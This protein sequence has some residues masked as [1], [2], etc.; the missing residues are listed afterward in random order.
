MRLIFRGEALHTR[1]HITAAAAAILLSMLTV[2]QAAAQSD[3][4][5]IELGVHFT[6]LRLSEF[7]TT[8]PGV[9]GRVTF[10]LTHNFGIEGEFNSYPRRLS[11]GFFVI[12][13]KLEGLFGLKSGIRSERAGIFGKVRPGFIHISQEPTPCPIV[14]PLPGGCLRLEKE[15]NFALDVGGVLEFYPSRRLVVRFDLGDTII[16][17]SGL[18]SSAGPAVFKTGGFTSHNLQAN[19]GVG[20]RF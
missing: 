8:E 13:Q 1:C 6:A 11:Q 20:I 18:L 2:S 5:K 12:N 4:P 19:F 3:T 16:R 15:T 17:Y 14:G 10:N 9:G 7:D